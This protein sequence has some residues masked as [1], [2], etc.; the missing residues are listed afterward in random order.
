MTEPLV[1]TPQQIIRKK[2]AGEPIEP[3]DNEISQA[4][5]IVVLVENTIGAFVR[6]INM[7]SARGFNIDSVTVGATEDPS[8][9]R[10]NIVTMGNGRIIAQILRQLSRL[11]DTI[12]VI[13]LSDTDFVE[14]ELCLLKVCYTQD[15]R[16]EILDINDIFGGKVVDITAKTMTFELRGPSKKIDAFIGMMATHTIVEVARSGR[17]AMQRDS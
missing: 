12:E 2:A 17:V 3:D 4:H 6:V 15:S 5:T 16:S 7:F 14:R 13:D 8:I 1:L 11:V 9:S 10:M